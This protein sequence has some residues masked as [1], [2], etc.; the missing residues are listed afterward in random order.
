[1]S[2]LGVCLPFV[3]L[4]VAAGQS[5]ARVKNRLVESGFLIWE[6]TESGILPSW[7][8][9]GIGLGVVGS[10]SYFLT[11]DIVPYRFDSTQCS[12]MPAKKDTASSRA[13]GQ[14]GKGGRT[15]MSSKRPYP[16]KPIELLN[17]QEF[18]DRFCLPNDIFV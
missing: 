16:G 17:E 13:A 18:R 6:A 3:C 12:N 7:A 10:G 15:I 14:G 9:W 2:L 4:K 8:P 5:L 1:M 11:I